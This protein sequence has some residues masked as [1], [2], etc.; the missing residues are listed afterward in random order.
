LTGI[1]NTGSFTNTGTATITGTL[2][3][4]TGRTNTTSAIT[5]T[6]Q[7]VDLIDQNWRG[8]INGLQ[9]FSGQFDYLYNADRNPTYTITSNY[10]TVGNL[11]NGDLTSNLAAPVSSLSATPLVIEIVRA[12]GGRI[13]YSD[14]LS[15]LFTGHRL[16][17]DGVVF[18][19]YS[20]ETKN[21]D[22]NYTFV[23]Q[24]TAVSE[25]VNLKSVPLHV[26]GEAYP[27]GTAT[28]HG[29]HGIRLTVSGAVASSFVAGNLQLNSIQLRDT[30]PQFTPAAGIG[31]IDSRGGSIYGDI[32][33]PSTSGT[34]LGTATSN[35]LSFW[36][37]TPIIQPTTSVAASAFVA[38][39][40]T[41]VNDASTFDGYTIKQVVKALRNEGLLA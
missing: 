13:N 11:F 35:K 9:A 38:S 10:G 24:R 19:D 16:N 1:T 36:N 31:A 29:I 32:G 5:N 17:S 40:G 7:T 26:L 33:M 18:T 3:T 22:G 28:W 12:D 39:A 23:S 20:V 4:G 34:K 25:S 2:N 14:T 30:R 27:D 6:L 15:L 37:A 41:A 8:S 21:S